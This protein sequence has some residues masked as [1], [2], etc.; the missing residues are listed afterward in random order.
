MEEG[1]GWRERRKAGDI[2]M[3]KKEEGMEKGKKS[4]GGASHMEN[5]N[6]C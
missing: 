6:Y 3:R 4:C 5:V 2:R 1:E